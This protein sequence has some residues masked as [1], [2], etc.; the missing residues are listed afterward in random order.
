[1]RGLYLM[2]VRYVL[3]R[4]RYGAFSPELEPSP[5]Y[6]IEDGILRLS[7]A[8]PLIVSTR[9]MSA[10]QVPGFEPHNI[11]ESRQYFDAN[12]FDYDE[13]LSRELIVPLI[14]AMDID[15]ERG[16][17]ET[18][19]VQGPSL[20]L[21]A[22][23]NENLVLE[24]RDFNVTLKTVEVRYRS[25]AEI[26]GRLAYSHFPYLEMAIDGRPVPFYRS[27][28]GYVLVRLPVGEHV[29]TRRGVASPMRRATLALSS[30]ALLLVLFVPAA[31]LRRFE[32][33]GAREPGAAGGDG[34]S[35]EAPL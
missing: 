3:F 16:T 17:A 26:Y 7:Q 4:D 31:A 22:G 11:I 33:P 25:N 30:A 5:D 2:G 15:L 20:P 18:L 35:E 23:R 24:I 9:A 32:A 1:V 14:D 10:A 12:T 6:E 27:A 29:L 34:R 19:L 21:L 13:R 8:R 28:M